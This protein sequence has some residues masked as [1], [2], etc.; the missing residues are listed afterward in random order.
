MIPVHCLL[1]II[2]LSYKYIFVMSA[3]EMSM[4]KSYNIDK[5]DGTSLKLIYGHKTDHLSAPRA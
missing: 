5:S 4:F 1:R 2:F 3:K